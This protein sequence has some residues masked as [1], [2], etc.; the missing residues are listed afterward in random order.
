[1]KGGTLYKKDFG[2]EEQWFHK[3]RSTVSRKARTEEEERIADKYLKT[4]K[5][6]L[7]RTRYDMVLPKSDKE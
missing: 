6:I 1:M 5:K 4:I 7:K 3:G 2:L